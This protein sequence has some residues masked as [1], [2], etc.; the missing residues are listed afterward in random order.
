MYAQTY[1]HLCLQTCQVCHKGDN[2]ACLL[3]CDGCDR[4]WHMFCLRPKVTQV[5]EGD[6]FCPTCNYMVMK[7][8]TQ[9]CTNSKICFVLFKMVLYFVYLTYLLAWFVRKLMKILSQN[10]QPDREQG[11]GNDVL[12]MEEKVLMRSSII[13]RTWPLHGKNAALSTP[14]GQAPCPLNADAWLHETSLTLHTASEQEILAFKTVFG[15]T[16]PLY[17]ISVKNS[18]SQC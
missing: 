1:T 10:N 5:P 16:F 17:Y 8:E 11:F 18:K 3:L 15:N 2:D 9:T 13:D 14:A 6:W 12:F 7:H 4:G